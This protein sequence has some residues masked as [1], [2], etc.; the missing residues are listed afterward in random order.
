[1]KILVTGGAGYIGSAT[2]AYFLRAGHE[3]VVYDNLMRGHREAIP[4]GVA[5]VEGDI[6]D[7]AQLDAAFAEHVPDAVAHFAAL[8]EAGESMQ[9]PGLYYEN[10]VS[11]TITLLE[12][13]MTHEVKRILLS[14]T[15]AVY[16]TQSTPLTEEDSIGPNNVYGE[17]KLVIERMLSWYHQIHGLKYCA[18]RYFNACGAMRDVEGHILRGEAHQPETHLIPLLLQVPLNQREV[19]HLFGTDY[20]TPDGTCI[21]DYIHIEDLARAHVLALAALDDMNT[22]IYNLGNGRGYSNREV[23]EI[24]REVTNHPI[25]VIDSDPRPGDA[26]ALVA[27]SDKIGEELG[28]EPHYADL[29]TIIQT[30]WDWHRTHPNGFQNA[31]DDK[32]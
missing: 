4:E 5:V 30:A 19:L 20:P 32:Q 10:N 11:G 28:W 22:M 27:S 21:R 14:S 29:H 7:R 15:A 9:K 16:A 31:H 18:L 17:T 13:M 3:V 24:A 12:S 25:R 1:L 26:P 8:I 23:I 6:R 2:T